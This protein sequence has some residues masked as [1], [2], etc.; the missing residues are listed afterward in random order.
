[1]Y[2]KKFPR[3][4]NSELYITEQR[5]SAWQNVTLMYS[6][7]KGTGFTKLSYNFSTMLEEYNDGTH[8]NYLISIVRLADLETVN[9]QDGVNSIR[10]TIGWKNP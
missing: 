3:D 8:E 5:Q 4:E 6:N 7:E 1:M 9:L 10:L 2:K